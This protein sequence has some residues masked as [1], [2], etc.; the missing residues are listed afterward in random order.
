MAGTTFYA[1]AVEDDVWDGCDNCGVGEDQYYDVYPYGTN[2]GYGVWTLCL[3]RNGQQ[4]TYT[5][6]FQEIAAGAP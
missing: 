5:I 4:A 3:T 6:N 1:D 2:G